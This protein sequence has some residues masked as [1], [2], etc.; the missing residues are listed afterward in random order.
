MV[1]WFMNCLRFSA[2]LTHFTDPGTPDSGE[3]AYVNNKAIYFIPAF[4]LGPDGDSRAL[5]NYLQYT[6]HS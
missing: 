1:A 4:L 6:A 3:K 5:S 2:V